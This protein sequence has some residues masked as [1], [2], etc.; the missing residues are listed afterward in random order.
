M[1]EES[2]VQNLFRAFSILL[3]PNATPRDYKEA[4]EYLRTVREEPKSIFFLCRALTN[5]T[6]STCNQVVVD[7]VYSFM[8]QYTATAMEEWVKAKSRS[9]TSEQL[10]EALSLCKGLLGCSCQ[11]GISH[12]AI[13]KCCKAATCCFVRLWWASDGRF[14]L[15]D[16]LETWWKDFVL[17]GQ[18][19]HIAPLVYLLFLEEIENL[20]SYGSGEDAERRAWLKSKASTV[21]SEVC[22]EL[23]RIGLDSDSSVN[24]EAYRKW[25]SDVLKRDCV[26]CLSKWNIYCP[27]G[28]S[29]DVLCSEL[30]D[31]QVVYEAAE[32]LADDVGRGGIAAKYILQ[33]C[34][35]LF[36]MLKRAQKHQKGSE[37]CKMA[38]AV[39]EV[40]AAIAEANVEYLM[41][42]LPEDTSVESE[43]SDKTAAFIELCDLLSFGLQ[44]GVNSAALAAL[45]GISHFAS[46]FCDLKTNGQLAKIASDH[47]QKF[48][49]FAQDCF[50]NL[51]YLLTA[52]E[53]SFLYAD[54]NSNST[55]M[56]EFQQIRVASQDVC[57]ELTK[58]LDANQIVC[59]VT[60]YISMDTSSLVLES[61][62]FLL[63]ATSSAILDSS[64]FNS[65]SKADVRHSIQYARLV[66]VM[67][68]ILQ[69][70][71]RR[72]YNG[73]PMYLE[74]SILK[75]FTSYSPLLLEESVEQSLF[76]P[77]MNIIPLCLGRNPAQASI[78]LRKLA[79]H[80]PQRLLPYAESLLQVMA[81]AEND[82]SD[83]KPTGEALARVLAAMQTA[84]DRYRSLC[85]LLQPYFTYLERVAQL[86]YVQNDTHH[87]EKNLT[88]VFSII[89]TICYAGGDVNACCK[90]IQEK[91]ELFS[92]FGHH[93]ASHENLAPEISKVFVDGLVGRA[94]D[95]TDK[96]QFAKGET[97]ANY[98]GFLIQVLDIL[99]DIF[100]K[101]DGEIYWMRSCTQLIP[102]LDVNDEACRNCVSN[103]FLRIWTACNHCITNYSI[104]VAWERQD[105][106][107]E[108]C[109][110]AQVTWIHYP[111][112]WLSWADRIFPLVLLGFY[113]SDANACTTV[114][115]FWQQLLS[116][117]TLR[118]FDDSSERHVRSSL[119]PKLLSYIIPFIEGTVYM[120]SEGISPRLTSH[121]SNLLLCFCQ[122]M[123]YQPNNASLSQWIQQ[124]M[125]QR[126]VSSNSFTEEMKDVFSFMLLQTIESFTLQP[127]SVN[128]R[129]FRCFVSDLCRVSRGEIMEDILLAYRR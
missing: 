52:S 9:V 121:L 106:I 90:I 86:L 48:Y 126:S 65:H 94:P 103:L 95:S 80:A 101:S 37:F 93:F 24:S 17:L 60:D 54:F 128:R 41:K 45:E 89:A 12:I 104:T 40:A 92:I 70:A 96:E 66:Q 114:L 119:S 108:W 69:I 77:I 98:M 46:C 6:W 85:I 18:Q 102:T 35:S 100:V 3:E 62:F 51:I 5:N 32:A 67:Y 74:T 87:E 20:P 118:S 43:A 27:R 82:F 122:W 25:P 97:W 83:Y 109:H 47:L 79:I 21:S 127:D 99:S 64:L 117:L 49:L 14:H 123:A 116:S 61:V 57:L 29:I 34:S 30:E 84:E 26:L 10:Y 75:L 16:L 72:L 53:E 8:V 31:P 78:L 38:H 59:F 39:L 113:V 105:L 68:P 111:N 22:S 11:K 7:D 124:A 13:E 110:F 1:D 36:S 112:I 107:A 63:S 15:E 33:T 44:S 28:S 50:Q 120:L 91:L 42:N 56:E 125:T 58:A 2:I 115:R 129:I 55:S 76:Q 19:F 73:P 88:Q 71:I 4:D 81:N 23:I